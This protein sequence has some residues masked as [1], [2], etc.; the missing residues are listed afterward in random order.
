MNKVKGYRIMAG[1]SQ[2]DMSQLLN[3]SEGTYRNKENRKTSFK[4]N[5]MAV[6]TSV[7]N[8]KGIDVKISDIFFVL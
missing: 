2:K 5:E 1:Y 6:F 8:K 7:I 4:E 3:I